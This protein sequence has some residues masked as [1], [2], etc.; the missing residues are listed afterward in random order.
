MAVTFT[1]IFGFNS[2][3]VFVTIR[4]SSARSRGSPATHMAETRSGVRCDTAAMI[5]RRILTRALFGAMLASGRATAP[6]AELTGVPEI[7][8]L[9]PG[10][11]AAMARFVAAFGRGLGEL[12]YVDG[13]SIRIAW[14]F[15]DEPDGDLAAELAR[16]PRRLVVAPTL[17]NVLA[18]Q[19]ANPLMPIVTVAVGDAVAAKLVS[20]MAR[21]GGMITGMTDYRS[22]FPNRRL[23][24]LR[25]VLPALTQI[26]FLA[27][28][29]VASS[30]QTAVAAT[31]Q[32]I[33]M[34][35]L[36]VR[37]PAD[38][39]PALA[40][41]GALRAQALL[42]APNP[43]TYTGRARI[44]AAAQAHRIPV[45]F[46]Y[47]DFMDVDAL[48]S[49]GADLGELYHEAARYVRDILQGTKA[50]DLPMREPTRVE[51]VI[52]QA[53]ARALGLDLPPSLLTEADR[54]I[55]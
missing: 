29:E 28:P 51:L 55:E 54:L 52:N 8:F 11:R 3:S 25:R 43:L 17:S 9:A 7:G 20:S 16:P 6:R 49:F 36:P 26:A 4:T 27:N 21:P 37:Q 30:R 13:D 40:R 34:I 5:T 39:E 44:S 1:L 42:V 22:D 46:G 2:A 32:G 38:L 23:Q 50:S 31:A 24:L 10:S 35:D 12:G 18:V 15:T 47:G 45:M 41:L 33:R 48:M 19:R 14:R 53:N